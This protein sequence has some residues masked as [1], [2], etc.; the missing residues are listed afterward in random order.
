MHPEPDAS[1]APPDAVNVMARAEEWPVPVYCS[2]PAPKLIA[3][4]LFPIAVFVPEFPM[5]LIDNTPLVIVVHLC[6]YWCQKS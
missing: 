3:A 4:E 5:E 6:R 1:I 2:V